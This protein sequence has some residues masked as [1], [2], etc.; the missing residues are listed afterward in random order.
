MHM[1]SHFSGLLYICKQNDRF[2]LFQIC[3][4]WCRYFLPPKR[5]G[6]GIHIVNIF[7][8]KHNTQ[9]TFL[10][11]SNI[12]FILIFFLSS[13]SIFALFH[14]ICYSIFWNSKRAAISITHPLDLP[15]H[16]CHVSLFLLKFLN[17]IINISSEAALISFYSVIHV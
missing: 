6:G 17:I 8:Y 1:N 15:M 14:Y 3:S 16:I 2:F 11:I 10:Y 4:R 13:S 12:T 5:G 9:K 7:M